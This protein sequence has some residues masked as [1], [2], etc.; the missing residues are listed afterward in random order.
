MSAFLLSRLL[1]P[2]LLL[3]ALLVVSACDSHNHDDDHFEGIQRVE[4]RE[5]GSNQLIA[6]YDR[7]TGTGFA[8][9]AHIH[10]DNVGDETAVNVLFFDAAGRQAELREGGEY[11]LGV[12]LATQA[13][14]G[15]A[16]ASGVVS[17]EAHGDHADITAL[18]EGTT[19]LVF[20]LMHGSHSDGDS[21]ALRVVVGED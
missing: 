15:V 2:G 9:S 4:V 19:H 12:R 13:R 6:S 1:R 5:R 11:S 14:D 20:Q 7:A 16:G 18:T 8:P 10:L 21:P 17:F 3:A